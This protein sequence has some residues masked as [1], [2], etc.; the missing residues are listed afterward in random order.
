MRGLRRQ[1]HGFAFAAMLA[2]MLA[3]GC[4]SGVSIKE[5]LLAPERAPVSPGHV[6]VFVN[7]AK[8]PTDPVFGARAHPPRAFLPVADLTLTWT[9]NPPRDSLEVKRA[10]ARAGGQ[11]GAD[12]VYVKRISSMVL[13][14]KG[15]LY[16]YSVGAAI[17]R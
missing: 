15:T 16:V 4:R 1:V 12:A 9:R 2:A 8:F 10:M 14:V 7:D 3:T 11:V 5:V 13:P 6:Q 17:W